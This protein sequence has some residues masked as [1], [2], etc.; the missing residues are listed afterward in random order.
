MCLVF[1]G[2]SVWCHAR[3]AGPIVLSW[4][5]RVA[6]RPWRFAF[7]LEIL[8]TRCNKKLVGYYC[9]QAFEDALEMQDGRKGAHKHAVSTTHDQAKSWDG[10]R[11]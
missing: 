11:H 4:G 6:C 8:A 10:K 3:A 1:V 2:A 5:S 7:R 9:R